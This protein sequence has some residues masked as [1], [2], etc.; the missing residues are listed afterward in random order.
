MLV[1]KT[2]TIKRELG[3]LSKVIDDDVERRLHNGIRH[4]EAEALRA[5]IEAADLDAERKR[6]AAEELEAARDR[7]DA[8][9]EQI[10]R[11]QTLLDRSRRWTGFGPEPF[12]DA[13]SCALG[14][15]GARG[16]TERR[17]ER[18]QPVW[19]FPVLD[20]RGATD[21]SWTATLDSL[22]KP[23]D[24]DQK[25]ADWRRDAPIRPVTFEDPGVVT[26]DTVQLHLGTA[27]RPAAACPVPRPGL[28]LP[29]SV[30]GV[31]GA[32]AGCRSPRP[33]AGTGFRST[34]KAPNGCT[35]RSSLS[36]PAGSNR[37]DEAIRC[38]PTPAKR[39]CAPWSCC[40]QR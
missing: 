23:R 36:P 29:R 2:E 9:A 31:P 32:N 6:V 19:E 5:A 22:R 10:E 16:L 7:Q 35:K 40:S 20:Q 34:A 37:A 11:C 17:N 4:G 26:E 25:V 8:L 24:I 21:P 30:A 33:A 18:R 27:R 13:L 1:G 14:L 12:R 38:D 3:S 15:L 28:R 39:R